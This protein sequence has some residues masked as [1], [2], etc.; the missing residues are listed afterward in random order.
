MSGAENLPKR[1]ESSAHIESGVAAR[2]KLLKRRA[3]ICTTTQPVT[4][5]VAVKTL[6]VEPPA[7]KMP[8]FACS[9]AR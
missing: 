8:R 6:D 7:A 2:P 3:K 4:L 1:I 5:T 9:A